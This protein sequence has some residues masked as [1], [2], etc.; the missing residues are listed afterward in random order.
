MTEGQKISELTPVTTLYDG[1]CFPIVQNGETRKVL[2]ATIQ[3]LLQGNDGEKGDAGTSLRFKEAWEPLTVYENDASYIDVVTYQ[4]NTYACKLAHTSSLSITPDNPD[5]WI[6]LAEHGK[7]GDKGDKG[8][9]GPMGP[10]G[11]KGLDGDNV[12][13]I[14]NAQFNA[15]A[16]AEA[17]DNNLN[18]LVTENFDDVSG[19]D[20]TDETTARVVAECYDANRML[21]AYNSP[22]TV[23]L[24]AAEVHLEKQPQYFWIRVDWEGSGELQIDIDMVG[25]KLFVN[26]ENC[27]CKYLLLG[28]RSRTIGANFHLTGEVTLKN[29]AWGVK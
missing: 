12:A 23:V 2:F 11:P 25:E 19:L 24:K 1:C 10:Q 16:Y 14:S 9:T 8:D 26:W 5:Y 27:E 22:D 15:E 3:E 21:L 17:K 6:L 4:G 29:V 13:L 18:I 7:D 20:L 28:Q